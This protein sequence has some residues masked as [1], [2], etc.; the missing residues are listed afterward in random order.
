VKLSGNFL[1]IV[2][3]CRLAKVGVRLKEWTCRGDGIPCHTLPASCDRR[4]N[5][6]RRV[7]ECYQYDLGLEPE[8]ARTD[9]EAVVVLADGFHTP[10]EPSLAVIAR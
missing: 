6:K 4:G 2:H 5:C 7:S 8:P 9:C 10:R 3:G 1:A